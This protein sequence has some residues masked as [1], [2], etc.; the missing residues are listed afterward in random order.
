MTKKCHNVESRSP[1]RRSRKKLRR[2]LE[3]EFLSQIIDLQ[4]H[5]IMFIIMNDILLLQYDNKHRYHQHMLNLVMYVNDNQTG[6]KFP[7]F[8]SSGEG[9]NVK[10]LW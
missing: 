2:S 4:R 8:V 9:P 3:G 6:G 7:S 5:M 1:W 10:I